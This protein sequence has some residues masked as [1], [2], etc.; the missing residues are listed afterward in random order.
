MTSK[1]I[2]DCIR[3][4]LYSKINF[5]L[6]SFSFKFLSIPNFLRM[7]H[8]KILTYVFMDNF[9]PGFSFSL[10]LSLFSLSLFHPLLLFLSRFHSSFLFLS[11]SLF[12]SFFLSLFLSLSLSIPLYLSLSLPQA[13]VFYDNSLRSWEVIKGRFLIFFSPSNF[14]RILKLWKCKFFLKWS[15]T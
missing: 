15:M 6:I 10:S 4:F 2:Y 7:I 3:S 8:I 14:C 12:L 9:C 5:S 13:P 11:L 1:V